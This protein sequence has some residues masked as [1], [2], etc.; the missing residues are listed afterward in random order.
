MLNTAKFGALG[1]IFLI[2]CLCGFALPYCVIKVL[3]KRYNKSTNTVNNVLSVLNCFSGGVFFSTSILVLLP[4]AREQIQ[5]A[6]IKFNDDENYPASELILGI[7]F[8]LI[9]IIE[10]VTIACHRRHTRVNDNQYRFE[11]KKP[12]QNGG[13]GHMMVTSISMTSMELK[14]NKDASSTLS[15]SRTDENNADGQFFG[16][17][18]TNLRNMIL[19]MA[20]SIH[21]VFDGL[22]LGLLHDENKVWS[23]LLALSIHKVLI[24]F[25]IGLKMCET[26]SFV[27]FAIAMVYLAAVSPIGVGIGIAL[28]LEGE[29]L[30]TNR[31]SAV[32]QS[33]AVGTFIYVALFEIL[34]KEFLPNEGNRLL[35]CSATVLGFALFAMT[36]TLLPD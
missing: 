12:I 18:M 34:L 7:G 31:A 30:A 16:Q 19:L 5:S 36:I 15:E 4:E 13:S 24:F 35:K 14:D 21:M 1:T 6:E 2:S 11:A 26:T 9:L 3:Q 27:K 10:N 20:F 22:E 33:F 8:L 23:I 25:S 17:D 32:L 28:S 29:S